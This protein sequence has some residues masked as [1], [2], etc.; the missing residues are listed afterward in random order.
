MSSVYEHVCQI[1]LTSAI[2]VIENDMSGQAG[3]W[4]VAKSRVMG[5]TVLYFHI[6][7]VFFLSVSVCHDSVSGCTITPKASPVSGSLAK[8]HHCLDGCAY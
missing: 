8:Q 1:K 4:L 7:T 5:E 2:W 6:D 3:W